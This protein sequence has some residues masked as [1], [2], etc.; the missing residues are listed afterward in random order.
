MGRPESNVTLPTLLV[1]GTI[2][3]GS[4]S[5]QYGFQIMRTTG[6]ASGSVYPIL[7]RLEK[8]G[9]IESRPE[10]INP[11]AEGRPP[12]RFYRITDAGR[13]QAEAEATLIRNVLTPQR[14]EA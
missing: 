12:R 7:A 3:A 4:G 8:R 6:L 11:R 1:L 10:T 14:E 13:V 5:E 2:A 9:L